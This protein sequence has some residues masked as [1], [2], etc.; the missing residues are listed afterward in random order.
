MCKSEAIWWANGPN[1]ILNNVNL[2]QLASSRLNHVIVPAVSS[3]RISLSEPFAAAPNLFLMTVWGCSGAYG[4]LNL[5]LSLSFPFLLSQTHISSP[6][7]WQSETQWLS[8][9]C[10]LIQE[11]SQTLGQTYGPPVFSG[12][13]SEVSHDV[14]CHVYYS[15]VDHTNHIYSFLYCLSTVILSFVQ[16]NSLSLV[17]KLL[18]MLM[19][20][21]PK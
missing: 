14:M 19:W 7:S 10:V 2:N 11:I 1:W 8:H 5:S 4:L 20:W 15:S 9:R 3:D 18:H 16:E 6:Y 17:R 12:T 21:F 13:F